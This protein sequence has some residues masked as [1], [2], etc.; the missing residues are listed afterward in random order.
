MSDSPDVA[1]NGIVLEKLTTVGWLISGTV[2]HIT[3]RTPKVA[4]QRSK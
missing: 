1:A 3:S 2:E 4:P